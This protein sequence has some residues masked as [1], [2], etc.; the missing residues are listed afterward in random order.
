MD[1]GDQDYLRASIDLYEQNLT[2][3]GIPHVYKISPGIHDAVYWQSQVQ[4]Y[5]DWY[6]QGFAGLN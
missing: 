3:A 1:R 4:N 2:Y 5:I 6:E